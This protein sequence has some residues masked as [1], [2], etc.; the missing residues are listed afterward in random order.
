MA[1]QGNKGNIRDKAQ[2]AAGAAR[3]TA[4]EAGHRAQE[5]ASALGHRAQE[6][7]SNVANQA[8]E[9]ASKAGQKAE[10]AVSSVGESMS[11]LAGTIRERAPQEGMLGTA[12]GA[13]ADRLQSS[14]QY[15][16]QHGLSDITEDLGAVIRRYPVQSVC[17]ALGIGWLLGMASRR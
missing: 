9:V 11:Q 17:V 6:A 15:L 16:Q 1:D 10:S 13:V 14:G 8:R 5:T 3:Q 12:A 2:E 4:Q 7:A